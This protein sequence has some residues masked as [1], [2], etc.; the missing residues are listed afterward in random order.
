MRWLQKREGEVA[1]KHMAFYRKRPRETPSSYFAFGQRKIAGAGE[2]VL[3]RAETRGF[4]L[5]SFSLHE[6]CCL[7]DGIT[8]SRVGL[9]DY[10]RCREA[11][12]RRF[13]NSIRGG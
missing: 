5:D 7:N 13:R 4:A 9:V 12:G 2:C 10:G 3:Q 1:I 6:G 8:R 11:A